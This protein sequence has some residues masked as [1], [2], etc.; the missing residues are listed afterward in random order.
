MFARV[1]AVNA[2]APAGSPRLFPMHRLALQAASDV[3]A[4]ARLDLARFIDTAEAEGK[5][6]AWAWTSP[7]SVL[8]LPAGQALAAVAD[9]MNA[10]Y[11]PATETVM[12]EL[13]VVHDPDTLSEFES[14]PKQSLDPAEAHYHFYTP[15]GVTIDGP[16]LLAALKGS[17]KLA[18]EGRGRRVCRGGCQHGARCTGN[19]SAG[20]E[21]APE[22][23]THPATPAATANCNNGT[24]GASDAGHNTNVSLPLPCRPPPPLPGPHV[25]A[26]VA[27][28]AHHLLACADR[29]ARVRQG[30]D[31]EWHLFVL[32][33]SLGTGCDVARSAYVCGCTH[34]R[35]CHSSRI[36]RLH[37][38]R[39][40]HPVACPRTVLCCMSR[41]PCCLA[42]LLCAQ[43]CKGGSCCSNFQ[44][45]PSSTI[46]R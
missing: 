12:L 36:V 13:E 39:A 44:P 35:V 24:R 32:Q 29:P 21:T 5:R 31:R 17:G 28:A 9:I 34:A 7:G 20:R 11:D 41:H 18:G 42:V 1:N 25:R 4:S 19:T 37:S 14:H 46:C 15:L 23:T 27:P 3:S 43:F 45:L 33:C 8:L 30:H 22:R 10:A 16:K 40:S 26:C 6:V 38:S 2:Q